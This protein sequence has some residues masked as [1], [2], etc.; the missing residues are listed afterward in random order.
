MDVVV[1]GG[2]VEG[3]WPPTTDPGP[4]LNRQMRRDIGLRS[5]EEAVGQAAHDFVTLAAVAKIAVLSC[6]RRRDNAPAVPARWLV[7]LAAYLE[8]QKQPLAHHPAAHWARMIDQ[9]EAGPQPVSA[10][11]PK[12]PVEMRPTTL[13]VTE[14]ETWLADPYAIYAKH[15]LKLRKLDP[16]EQGTDAADYGSVVHAGIAR[17]I[18]EHGAT[19]PANGGAVLREAFE[20]EMNEA[21]LRPA[22]I[23][24]WRPRLGLIADWIDE[25]EC[26]RRQSKP[27]VA[28]V[29]EKDG[30]TDLATA[31]GFRLR[32][33]AD[34]IEKLADGTIA[35]LDYKTGVAPKANDVEGGKAPQLTLEAAMIARAGFGA[36]WE[37]V[38]SELSY[39]KLGGASA[40]GEVTPAVKDQAAIP[41]AAAA[42]LASL[43]ARIEEFDDPDTAY[44]AHPHPEFLPRFPDYAQLARVAEWK[45]EEEE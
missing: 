41:Q 1:L 34:R 45:R 36:Q 9:P 18:G 8:G 35:L 40:P 28:V 15:I 17:V 5:P 16:L 43:F 38:V 23:A 3:V 21:S 32:G 39:W 7:R 29:A 22:L 6:P 13:S 24:W 14:I 37:G 42:A 44:L 26:Q 12:P 19:W 4:W 25:M 10:P 2:L 33:V 11:R 30:H 20:K 31:R 27:R